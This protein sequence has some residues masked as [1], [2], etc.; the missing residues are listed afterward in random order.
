VKDILKIKNLEV[1][2]GLSQKVV[3]ARQ[4][5]AIAQ[6]EFLSSGGSIACQ[7]K[8]RECLHHFIPVSNAE[9]NF[10]KQK[11]RNRWLNL[12]D[13][14][15]FFF[16]NSVKIRNSSNLIKQLKD[17]K[18]NCFYDFQQIKELA[19]EFYQKLIGS[20]SHVFSQDKTDQVS[21][22]IKKKFSANSVLGMNT[23]ITRTGI[24]KVLFSMSK[25][26][27]PGLDGFSTAFF[28]SAWPIIGDNVCEA[29]LEFFHCGKLLKE[30]N[31][32]IITL[33]L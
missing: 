30:V 2:G 22:L 9:E 6:S 15:N 16:H 12:G 27:A 31:S 14:N 29:V 17:E 1:F 4:N 26:K 19:I 3:Q 24:R 25:N 28:H 32:T 23:D 33:V 10:L 7:R 21:G 18:G 13:G 8:E 5:L 11:S 20:S